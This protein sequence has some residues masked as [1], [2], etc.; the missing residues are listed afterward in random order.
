MY[1]INEIRSTREESRIFDN[2]ILTIF[3][4]AEISLVHSFSN[5]FFRFAQE[6][7]NNGEK[8]EEADSA[9][10]C[11]SGCSS[12]TLEYEKE[13]AYY[14]D[15]EESLLKKSTQDV[16]TKQVVEP[17]DT[18]SSAAQFYSHVLLY[19]DIYDNKRILYVIGKL[20]DI[21][22][23]NAKAFLFAASTNLVSS[24]TS[25]VN[26]L[27]KHRNSVFA[28]GFQESEKSSETLYKN[29]SYLEALITICFYY[30][31]SYYPNLGSVDMPVS[32]ISGNRQ[33]G[34]YFSFVTPLD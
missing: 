9:I 11:T 23:V 17:S 5:I 13:A 30:V 8:E 7:A 34:R 15:D 16:D 26:L 33:V 22:R 31:R 28:K 19:C 3:S 12:V 29:T 6:N 4:G 32:E 24:R 25:L 27:A 21:I 14:C 20:R 2:N 1:R 18:S 10:S